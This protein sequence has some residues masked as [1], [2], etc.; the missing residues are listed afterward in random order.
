NTSINLQINDKHWF[1]ISEYTTFA[2]LNTEYVLHKNIGYWAYITNKETGNR[3]ARWKNPLTSPTSNYFE[4]LDQSL[5]DY[6][7]LFLG[8]FHTYL[9]E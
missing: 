2:I 4:M 8:I 9:Y 1:K 3:L 7:L 5:N 6:E